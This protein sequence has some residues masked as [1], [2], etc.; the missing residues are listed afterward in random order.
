MAK[1]K[2]P[3]FLAVIGMDNDGETMTFTGRYDDD[4]NEVVPFATQKEAENFAKEMTD[5]D[6]AI[7]VQQI[8]AYRR[9]IVR[10]KV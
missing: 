2:Q 8:C 7:V 9:K 4:K 5:W 6:N 10:E 1:K 3:S